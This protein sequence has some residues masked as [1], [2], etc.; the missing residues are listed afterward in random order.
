MVSLF[1]SVHVL[2][3]K[4]VIDVIS[5]RFLH[6]FRE[7]YITT[8]HPIMIDLKWHNT[9]LQLMPWNMLL[10]KASIL[11]PSNKL[12]KISHSSHRP[13]I[14]KIPTSSLSSQISPLLLRLVRSTSQALISEIK[15]HQLLR[16]KVDRDLSSPLHLDARLRP[17]CRSTV[18]V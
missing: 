9:R 5:G 3:L 10:L 2:K 12:T 14:L 16:I 17:R 11:Y 18:K 1:V 4:R 15:I 7:G 8:M 13:K 6:Y